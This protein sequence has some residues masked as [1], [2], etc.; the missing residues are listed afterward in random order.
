M[1]TEFNICLVQLR[2]VRTKILSHFSSALPYSKSLR[3]EQSSQFHQQATQNWMRSPPGL[4]KAPRKKKKS[5]EQEENRTPNRNLKEQE[6]V[7]APVA[8]TIKD[9]YWPQKAPPLPARLLGYSP[10]RP[11]P[12][13]DP[14]RV[15]QTGGQVP[16]LV[17]RPAPAMGFVLGVGCFTR[18]VQE[19]VPGFGDPW[20]V[21]GSRGGDRA[22]DSLGEGLVGLGPRRSHRMGSGL[23]DGPLSAN[24]QGGWCYHAPTFCKRP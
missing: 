15:S 22:R 13:E 23:A 18:V 10:A 6:L 17:L 4:G 20:R 8:P 21:C 2:K 14:E 16:A 12:P 9:A 5:G 24:A 3:R 19:R 11:R 7:F 1:I